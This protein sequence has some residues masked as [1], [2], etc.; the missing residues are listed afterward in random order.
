M[1]N[2]VLYLFSRKCAKAGVSWEASV[3]NKNKIISGEPPLVPN[4]Y[5]SVF[6]RIILTSVLLSMQ[7]SLC[8]KC[9]THLELMSL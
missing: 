5:P 9:I 4:A 1:C 7:L 2:P 3:L 8:A 6:F